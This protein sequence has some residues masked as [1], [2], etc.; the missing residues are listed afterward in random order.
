MTTGPS[1]I[2]VSLH[3]LRSLRALHLRA[4]THPPAI[5]HATSHHISSH[6]AGAQL[7]PVDKAADVEELLQLAITD[8]VQQPARALQ[9]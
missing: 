6:A 9:V 8:F 3:A 7:V 1:S 5:R 2:A 4:Y